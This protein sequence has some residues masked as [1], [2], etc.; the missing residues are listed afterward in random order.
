[1]NDTT[2]EVKEE[3]REEYYA[4]SDISLASFFLCNR[5]E[6]LDTRKETKSRVTFLFEKGEDTN[7]LARQFFNGARV[8]ARRFANTMRDLKGLIANK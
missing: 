8:E 2:V 1:M 7:K 4:T 3:E 5:V 6:M